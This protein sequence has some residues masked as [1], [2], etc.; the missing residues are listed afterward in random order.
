MSLHLKY[1]E[2]LDNKPLSYVEK[3]VVCQSLEVNVV[4]VN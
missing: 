1:Q 4:E 3:F 2:Y